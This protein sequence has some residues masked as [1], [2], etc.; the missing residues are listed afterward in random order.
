[1]EMRTE[2]EGIKTPANGDSD[3]LNEE[4]EREGGE[5]S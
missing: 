3:P 1:M 5:E 4:V 2:K